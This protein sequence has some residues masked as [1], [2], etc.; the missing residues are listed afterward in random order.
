MSRYDI[1]TR[2]VENHLAL[3]DG[4]TLSFGQEIDLISR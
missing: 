1:G 4:N 2:K 3:I